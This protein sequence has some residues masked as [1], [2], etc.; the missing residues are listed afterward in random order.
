MVTPQQL[1][2]LDKMFAAATYA[3]RT[4]TPWTLSISPDAYAAAAACEA[5][6]ETGWGQHM[7]ADSNNVLGIKNFRGYTGPVARADGTEQLPG[8]K[9]TAPTEDEWGMFKTTEACF[10]EQLLILREPRY[11]PAVA[12]STIEAYIIAE[13]AIWSTG[14]AKGTSVIQTYHAHKDLLVP[15][16]I[17]VPS[18]SS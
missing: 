18:I 5:A 1:L 10:V 12:A 14:L 3:A 13:C 17:Q 4:F 15:A 9:W 2:F 6:I 8:G 7:P 16:A 11:A